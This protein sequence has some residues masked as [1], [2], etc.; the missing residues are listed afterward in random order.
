MT[1]RKSDRVP[2][3]LPVQ[4]SCDTWLDFV[5]LYT[6]DI[7]HGGMFI[8][9]ASAPPLYSKVTVVLRLPG[10]VAEL[11][12][13]GEVVH[14]I[15]AKGSSD[16]DE[17]Q[18]FGIHLGDLDDET[19]RAVEAL[20][21]HARGQLGDDERGIVLEAVRDMGSAKTTSMASGAEYQLIMEL[22]EEL[23]TLKELDDF[24]VLGLESAA[25]VSDVRA[26]FFE[27]SKQWHPDRFQRAGA[28]VKSLS[29]QIFIRIKDA[30]ARLGDP[31]K[32]KEYRA[33]RAPRVAAQQE[34]APPAARQA[35]TTA[36]SAAATP[37][38]DAPTAQTASAPFSAGQ[39]PAPEAELPP[40][41]QR[42]PRKRR[43][44]STI[45]NKF[46]RSVLEQSSQRGSGA[47]RSVGP[48]RRPSPSPEPQPAGSSSKRTTE[49]VVGKSPSL[50][51][52]DARVSQALACMAGKRHAEAIQLLLSALEF[53]PKHAKARVLLPLSEARLLASEG[54]RDEAIARYKAVLKLDPQHAEAKRELDEVERAP[55]PEKKRGG[56]FSRI[57]TRQ[58]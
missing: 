58:D 24:E 33:A 37:S 4:V 31:K 32:L 26:A 6:K 3:Q 49:S 41:S 7:S 52:A 42:R 29:T 40:E 54:K 16:S 39:Q 25:S 19:R 51:E 14:I 17:K 55:Q 36:A 53:V 10:D 2:A 13:P 21:M 30:Y 9:A 44:R 1:T 8:Q 46:M 38:F 18:G 47:P 23:S 57:L 5:D 12:L 56:L 43:K 48:D 22:R 28:E 45:A 50:I 34:Q 11:K 27:T 35:Q 20:V 15:A